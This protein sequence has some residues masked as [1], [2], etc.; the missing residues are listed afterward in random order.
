MSEN[1]GLSPVA[2]GIVFFL[3][4]PTVMAGVIPWWMTRWQFQP[5]LLGVED[6]RWLGAIMIALGAPLLVYAVAWLA[7]EGVH[8][9][10]PIKK[11]IT[12][13]PYAY[14]RNPMYLGVV[15]VM[16]GQGLLFGSRGVFIYG[17]CWFAAF[18]V[19]ELTAD[20]P[21]IRKHIGPAYDDY[22][23]DVPG[24]IPRKPRPKA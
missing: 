16:V 1:S 12:N 24:W 7:H 13:G 11:L 17:W 3:C 6:L 22:M 9:Y 10:P 14:T 15:M 4:V 18:W 5:P 23:R 21:F 20:D 2:G 19:F 8:P